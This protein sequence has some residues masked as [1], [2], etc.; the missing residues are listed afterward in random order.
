VGKGPEHTLINSTRDRVGSG[1]RPSPFVGELHGVGAG[2]FLG[3]AP[4]QQALALQ[5][6]DDIGHRR[7]I[8]ACAIDQAGLAQ[9]LIL[10]HSHEHGELARGEIGNFGVEDVGGALASTMQKMDW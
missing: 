10:R 1:Q 3:A 5:T 6:P 7:A 9:T 8:D 4:L 2:V